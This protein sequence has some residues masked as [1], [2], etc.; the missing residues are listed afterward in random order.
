M[1]SIPRSFMLLKFHDSEDF[2]LL[3]EANEQLRLK[4][5][6]ETKQRISIYIEKMNILSKALR[7]A[8]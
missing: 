1:V 6:E 2:Q 7:E 5:I 3:D 4:S 8:R